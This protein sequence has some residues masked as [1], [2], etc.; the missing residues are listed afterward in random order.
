[1]RKQVPITE[2]QHALI[3]A[4]QR[5]QRGLITSPKQFVLGHPTKGG[6]FVGRYV[7]IKGELKARLLSWGTISFRRE[8]NVVTHTR[9]FTGR[10][11]T[12]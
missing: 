3:D 5:I 1:M 7:A 11:E 6:Y 8:E 10:Q 4:E 12:A 9:R 2:A